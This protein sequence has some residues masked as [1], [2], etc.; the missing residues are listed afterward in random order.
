[1]THRIVRFTERLLIA[2]FLALGLALLPLPL[3]TPSMVIQVYIPGIILVLV[4]Y[5]GKLIIDTFFYDR[6]P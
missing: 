6:H 3:R 5:I 1:M 4:C 2:L